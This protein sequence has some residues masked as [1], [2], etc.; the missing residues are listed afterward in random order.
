M[1]ISSLDWGKKRH[2]YTFLIL[3]GHILSSKKTAKVLDE[4]T[5][6]NDY[7]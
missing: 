1:N 6:N 5:N 2:V 7:H 4:S 3:D